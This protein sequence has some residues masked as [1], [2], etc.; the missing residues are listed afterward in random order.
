MKKVTL[1]IP[2]AMASRVWSH[3]TIINVATG[4]LE[5]KC[6]EKIYHIRGTICVEEE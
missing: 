3:C 4:W 2:N 6:S 5:F 1:Y